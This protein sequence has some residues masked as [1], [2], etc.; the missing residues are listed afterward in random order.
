MI[1]YTVYAEMILPDGSHMWLRYITQAVT[2]QEAAAVAT[3]E[4]MASAGVGSR[5]RLLEVYGEESCSRYR[6]T[7]PRPW[8][9]EEA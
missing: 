4:L 5:I 8:A 6:P 9:V 2:S 7:G 1:G 3:A